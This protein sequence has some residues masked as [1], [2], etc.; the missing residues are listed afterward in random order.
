MSGLEVAGL[1][2]GAI[3][4]LLMS[5]RGISEELGRAHDWWDFEATFDNLLF[6]IEAQKSLYR[7]NLRLLVEP[8]SLPEGEIKALLE[9]TK[10]E[11]WNQANVQS[12]L[13]ARFDE[14]D[15]IFMTRRL[16][17]MHQSV[18]ALQALLPLDE[19]C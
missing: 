3:P 18:V 10:L 17:A 13:R 16:R 7:Q 14:E 2:L 1:V 11:V 5:A 9:G 6:V 8:L 15:Y 19:V 12:S 4:L